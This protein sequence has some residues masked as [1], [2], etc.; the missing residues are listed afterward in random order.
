[1]SSL[2]ELPDDVLSAVAADAEIPPFK[3]SFCIDLTLE[4]QG[5]S[6]VHNPE[7]QDLP[8]QSI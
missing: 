5:Y 2:I 4:Q 6:Y 7:T 8:L 1:M 3:H